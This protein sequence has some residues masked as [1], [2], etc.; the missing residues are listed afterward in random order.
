MSQSQ[1]QTLAEKEVS[2]ELE[3]VVWIGHSSTYSKNS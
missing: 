3:D 2:L 1:G